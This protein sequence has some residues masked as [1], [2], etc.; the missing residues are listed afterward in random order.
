MSIASSEHRASDVV[1]CSYHRYWSRFSLFAVSAA[2]LICA[3]IDAR[4]NLPR[5]AR[6]RWKQDVQS[7]GGRAHATS[8]FQ[9]LP[10]LTDATRHDT[11]NRAILPR[12]TD[13]RASRRNAFASGSDEI[14]RQPRSPRMQPTLEACAKCRLTS[15]HGTSGRGRHLLCRCQ[16]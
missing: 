16:R 10:M 4:N 1:Q 11:A 3:F 14:D 8:I 12:I 6:Q 15:F 9:M 2:D 5:V 7:D 13:S